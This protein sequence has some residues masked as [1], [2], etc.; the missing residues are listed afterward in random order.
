[1]VGGGRR[2]AGKSAP[3]A[4][5]RLLFGEFSRLRRERTATAVVL[6]LGGVFTPERKFDY[7]GVAELLLVAAEENV[8]L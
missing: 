1:M 5:L 7:C 6:L 2:G 8:T 3:R 4:R